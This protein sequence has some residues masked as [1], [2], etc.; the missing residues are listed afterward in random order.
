MAV[1]IMIIY[2]EI[3]YNLSLSLSPSRFSSLLTTNKI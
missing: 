2:K 1:I 3:Y